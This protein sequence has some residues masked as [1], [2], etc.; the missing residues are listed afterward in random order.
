[1]MLG[2]LLIYYEIEPLKERPRATWLGRALIPPKV[3]LVLKRRKHAL[4]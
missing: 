4:E 2:H 3:D 1:M